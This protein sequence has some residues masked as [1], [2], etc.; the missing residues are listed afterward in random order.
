[1]RV[2]VGK[3]S[4]WLVVLATPALGQSELSRAFEMERQ[5]R[6]TEA[7]DLYRGML[8]GDQVSTPALLGLER[9]YGPLGLLDSL[10]PI[11][12]R[13]TDG[14]VMPSTLRGLE[15]RVF[16]RLRMDDSVAA[17]VVRWAAVAPGDEAP[18][19]EWVNALLTIGQVREAQRV[20]VQGR[21]QL[22]GP[23]A[24]APEVARVAVMLGNWDQAAIEWRRAVARDAGHFST[25][26]ADLGLAPP[27]ARSRVV[28]T[29]SAGGHPDGTRLAAE[30]LLGW[31]DPEQA[32]I[33]FSRALP[34]SVREQV[35]WLRRFVDQARLDRTRSGRR[36]YGLA[37][38]QLAE[39]SPD[40]DASR[41]RAEAARAFSQAGDNDAARRMLERLAAGE[42]A[43]PSVAAVAQ[44]TLIGLLV[45]EG[46]LEEADRRYREWEGRL[47]VDE[48]VPLMEQIAWGWIRR[49]EFEKASTVV[50]AIMLGGSW[51]NWLHLET[52]AY[53]A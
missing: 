24:L 47:A 28:R 43:P 10:I 11:L 2:A 31:G 4:L 51:G 9:V 21:R 46:K 45:D 48:R 39:I 12:R 5:G 33:L 22:G 14:R 36:V 32:W 52:T 41:F 23:P 18:Y 44:A 30:L 37:L 26:E 25:A 53:S 6:Y 20:L 1:M 27:Q 49:G 16:A 7:A 35:I 42:Q 19:R 17:A 34:R 40:P 50:A 38:E 8:G 3:L 29:L 13:E 15:V